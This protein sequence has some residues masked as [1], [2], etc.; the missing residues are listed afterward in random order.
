MM[1]IVWQR[2][3]ASEEIDAAVAFLKAD[4]AEGAPNDEALS[5]LEQLAQALLATNELMFVD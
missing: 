3:P 1:E 2:P 5:P 4:K